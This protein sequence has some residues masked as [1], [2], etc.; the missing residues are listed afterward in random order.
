M[1]G[2]GCVGGHSACRPYCL[3][4]TRGVNGDSASTETSAGPS[5][6]RPQL[7]RRGG[8]RLHY[9][10]EGPRDAPPILFAPRQRHLE[11][12]L[13]APD[14]GAARAAGHRCVAFDHLGFGRSDKP[15]HLGRY[16]LQTHVDNALALIDELDLRDVLLVAH[17]WGGPIGLGAMLERRE[18]L[19]GVVLMNTWAW[20]LPSFLPPFLREFRME[21]LGEI[22]ALGGNLFVESIPG[23]M[24]RRE[25]DPVMMDAYRAPFPD[26]WSRVGTLAFQREIPL[27]ERDRSAPL[28]GSIH[29]RLPD[30]DV[31]VLL[32]W[33]M[34]DRVFQPVFLEQWLEL[35]PDARQRRARGRG[36]LP[37][38]GRPRR[39]DRRDRRLRRDAEGARLAGGGDAAR[40]RLDALDVAR[41]HL[42]APAVAEHDVQHHAAEAAGERA[43]LVL[44]GVD[45]VLGDLAGLQEAAGQRPVELACRELQ[46]LGAEVAGGDG[47][48]R[49]R[50]SPRRCRRRARGASS[51]TRR[52]QLLRV[53]VGAEVVEDLLEPLA[54]E[55]AVGRARLDQAVGE[56]AGGR[57]GHERHRRL[58]QAG[59]QADA[60]RRRRRGRDR[61]RAGACR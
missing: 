22:L 49:A 5:P 10:D 28:M 34:R 35:F 31:P 33:G 14:R 50:S 21:G 24:A 54:A 29:R 15:P 20:E 11:L 40:G 2:G 45:V 12:P 47:G 23:G 16:S 32:V 60:D 1:Q 55:D 6:S 19:R 56:E 53:R 17:D 52:D 43:R 58:A 13:A 41:E 46:L 42:D 18:R 48:G 26:Y 61:G 30:L 9:V 25:V 3:V 57:A 38:R 59:A 8:R 44:G 4:Y 36:A 39:G 7:P 27:T 51:A 37:R